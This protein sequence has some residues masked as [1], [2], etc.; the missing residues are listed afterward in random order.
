M[1]LPGWIALVEKRRKTRALPAIAPDGMHDTR[2]LAS[3]GPVTKVM[4]GLPMSTPVTPAANPM[5]PQPPVSL[6]ARRRGAAIDLSLDAA[7]AYLAC[8]QDL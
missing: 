8:L 1:Q 7:L 2:F 6:G 3:I 4:V 5:C